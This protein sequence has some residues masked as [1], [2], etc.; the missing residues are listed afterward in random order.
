MATDLNK[1][2]P[3]FNAKKVAQA[4]RSWEGYLQSECDVVYNFYSAGTAAP[5]EKAKCQL[6]L[7]TDRIAE[8]QPLIHVEQGS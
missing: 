4:Q 7:T 6:E 5:Y 1:V 8:L 2:S 3:L